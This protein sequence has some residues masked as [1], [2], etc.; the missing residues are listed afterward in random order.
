MREHNLFSA[1]A[2]DQGEEE[3]GCEQGG[4]GDELG[5]CLR[6]G[7]QRLRSP[8]TVLFTEV[9]DDCLA[10]R[11]SAP[12]IKVLP[13]AQLCENYSL[14]SGDQGN[15]ESETGIR[16]VQTTGLSL[17]TQLPEPRNPEAP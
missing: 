15:Q 4:G 2:L 11:V 14:L 6:Q 7:E 13:G 17:L 8:R 10:G 12:G 16:G 9:T 3:E 5:S 1:A